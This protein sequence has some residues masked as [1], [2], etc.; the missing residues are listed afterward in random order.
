MTSSAFIA[1][2]LDPLIDPQFAEQDLLF[3]KVFIN[4]DDQISR[5]YLRGF[6]R[7]STYGLDWAGDKL[8]VATKD[9]NLRLFDPERG[10]EERSWSGEWMACQCDPNNPH[11]AAAVAWSGKFRVFDTRSAS[12][13]IFDVDLKKSAQNMK[14][15]LT[16]CWSPD[17]KYIAV[18]N[19]SDQIYLLDLRQP[20]SLRLGP[21]KTIQH[22][23]NQMVWTVEG[24]ALWI[25]TCGTPGKIHIIP[26]PSLQNEG[27]AAVVA[28][29]HAAI[30]LATDPTGRHIASGGGDCLVTLWD[31]KHLVC[32]RS[33]GNATQAVTTMGF[34]HTGSLLAW[35][36]GGSG[37]SG[38]ERNLTIVG[39]NTG[40]L[41][42]QDTTSAPVQQTRWHPKRNVLAYS[43]NVSQLPDEH[44]RRRM[45]SRD[46]AVVHILKIPE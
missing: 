30:S 4:S 8:L 13:A 5:D 10:E 37:S 39:A 3:D 46:S 9:N 2:V 24:D 35:G 15:F 7:C 12:S 33:F 22:E 34:N 25:A 43:L 44:D 28:H 29:Q 17:S 23:I 41:Y 1:H 40:V 32:T 11:I 26:T 6:K 38:G 16:L 31:P 36:T 45:N 20:G 21:S 19:R 18:N 42:W 14:E 27:A